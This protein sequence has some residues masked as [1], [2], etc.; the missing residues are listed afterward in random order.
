MSHG[1]LVLYLAGTREFHRPERS[2]RC[3]GHLRQQVAAAESLPLAPPPGPVPASVAEGQVQLLRLDRVAQSLGT[4][5]LPAP[6]HFVFI[7]T[8]QS[9]ERFRR[10]DTSALAP[11]LDRWCRE[12][13]FGSTY[14]VL[15]APPHQLDGAGTE[16][17]AKMD[18]RLSQA[19]RVILVAGGGP[20]ALQIAAHFAVFEGVRHRDDVTVMQLE[21]VRGGP[22]EGQTATGFPTDTRVRPIRQF[23]RLVG[24]RTIEQHAAELITQLDLPGAAQ[25]LQA[26][27]AAGLGPTGAQTHASVLL[28]RLSRQQAS[29]EPTEQLESALS[30]AEVEWSRPGGS[31][32]EALWYSSLAVV[33]LLPSAWTAS[34]GRDVWVGNTNELCDAYNDG[35]K[36]PRRKDEWSGLQLAS[37][38]FQAAGPLL[39]AGPPVIHLPRRSLPLQELLGERHRGDLP[40][41]TLLWAALRVT[42]RQLRNDNAH[43]MIGL[44]LAAAEERLR[45]ESDRFIDSVEYLDGRGERPWPPSP[46]AEGEASA[47]RRQLVSTA[48]HGCGPLEL[49]VSLDQPSSPF[50]RLLRVLVPS[51]SDANPMIDSARKLRAELVD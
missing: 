25:L 19:R 7:L 31:R 22:D 43:E 49:T 27:Q 50:R 38:S 1:S 5:E 11:V 41:Q 21:E 26:A 51:L 2:L 4:L 46:T 39:A 3:N 48:P 33:D 16:L 37:R 45:R 36:H 15:S 8:D 12:R 34:R 29:E 20:A 30:L 6:V 42:F 9:D 24:E 40:D 28:K 23:H 32:A 35:V 18:E 10:S 17:I 44:S 14:E 47:L 13:G